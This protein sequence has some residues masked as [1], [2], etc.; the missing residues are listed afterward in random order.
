MSLEESTEVKTKLRVVRHRKAKPH[1]QRAEFLDSLE[2]V[3]V[4]HKFEQKTC[5]DCHEK[6]TPIGK[7]CVYRE[8]GLKQP[9][10]FCRN[11]YQ[12]TYKCNHCHPKGGDKII[13]SKV[14]TS[15]I[16]P[17]SYFSS[18]V[19]AK[20]I[21]DKYGM[22]V[23]LNKQEM[24]FKHL[25]L[26]MDTNKMSRAI[27][28]LSEQ[29]EFVYNELT[30]ILLKNPVIHMDETPFQVLE[31][32]N[33]SKSYFWV[34]RSTEEFSNQ[35]IAVFSYSSNRKQE[36]ISELVGDYTGAIMCDGYNAYSSEMYPQITFGSCLVHI[37]RHFTDITKSL[38]Q[39]KESS[40]L[41]AVKLLMRI[42][43]KEKNFEYQS[44]TEKAQKR[45]LYLKECI[46]KFYNFLE[47]IINP[48]GKL[49][50]AVEHAQKF[51]SRLE[52]IYEIGELPLS[53]NAAEQV[54]R[55]STLIRKN[56]LF[57]KSTAGAR[58]SAIFYSLVQT[59]KLNKLDIFK[60]FNYIFSLLEK[61][62]NVKVEAYLPWN[63]EVKK[64]CAK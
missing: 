37:R 53:N 39:G 24:F 12:Q 36:N 47:T 40:A 19:L 21:V 43:E 18:S 11:H 48:S 38:Q 14:P 58:A 22:A 35:Q 10:L 62:E 61:R 42:F 5:T 26:P 2:Q 20:I 59:A 64:I 44:A 51:R 17:H 27:I 56:S 50:R 30:K 28:K 49:K 33:R 31:E 54:I 46:D 57:A 34:M 25:G 13:V 9:E 4:I 8:V 16:F 45:K 29:L 52:Q 23:P 41:K 60:Y 15:P 1:G 63:P 6:L 55:L 32:K 3:D 7:K